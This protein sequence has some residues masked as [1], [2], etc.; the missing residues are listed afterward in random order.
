MKNNNK[1]FT[2]KEMKIG[3]REI[4]P[5]YEIKNIYPVRAKPL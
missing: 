4:N 1:I 5:E 3:G 2:I